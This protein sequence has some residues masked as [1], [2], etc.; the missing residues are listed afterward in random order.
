MCVL[1]CVYAHIVLVCVYACMMALMN[2]INNNDAH[3]DDQ[4]LR[5]EHGNMRENST[6]TCVCPHSTR[7]CVCNT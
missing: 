5:G 6:C 1:V 7:M 3:A 4:H 2:M